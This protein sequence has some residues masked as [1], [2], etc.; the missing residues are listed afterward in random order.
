LL[1]D[2]ASAEYVSDF[3]CFYALLSQHMYFVEKTVSFE[4]MNS[5]SLPAGYRHSKIASV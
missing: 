5:R 3:L 4:V 2:E 1:K